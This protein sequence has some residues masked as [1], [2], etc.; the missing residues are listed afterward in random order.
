MILEDGMSASLGEERRLKQLLCSFS[1]QLKP[2]KV[3]QVAN[4]L[5]HTDTDRAKLPVS[6]SFEG[7]LNFSASLAPVVKTQ[8]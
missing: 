4:S 5:I 8:N 2:F 1:H 6:K 3:N 7:L